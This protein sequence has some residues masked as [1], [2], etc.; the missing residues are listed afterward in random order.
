MYKTVFIFLIIQISSFC[1]VRAQTMRDILQQMPDTILP[2]LSRG[3][4]LDFPDY[5]D[6]QMKAELS[7]RLGGTSEMLILTDDYTAIQL[8]KASSIQLKLL[9][10]GKK[11]IICAVRT[12][13]ACDTIHDS[14]IQFYQA[15]WK[16]L[17]TSKFLIADKEK[18]SFAHATLSAL[19]TNLVL[20]Y[21]YPLDLQFEG[22]EPRTH[23]LKKAVFRWNGKKFTK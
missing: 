19:N 4:L 16:P 5:L 14:Q 3:N 21:T 10:H 13:T 12:Y 22:E 15:D 17:K 9:P 7:N 18:D 23:N 6:S 11:K 20:E 1:S 2:L 8:S